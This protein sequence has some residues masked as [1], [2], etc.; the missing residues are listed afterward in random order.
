MNKKHLAGMLLLTLMV[1]A[2]GKDKGNNNNDVTQYPPV[3]TQNPNTSYTPAFQGQTRIYG[4]KT[5]AELDVKVLREGLQ[6]PWGL[7]ALPNGNWLVT[8]KNGTMLVLNADGSTKSTINGLPAVNSGGQGGLLG[9]ALDPQFAQNRMVYWTFSENVSGGTV[10]AVAKGMLA[11]NEGS[12]SNIDVI[13]RAMP[14]YQGQLHYGGRLVFDQTGNLLVSTGER[15]DL[16]TRPLAQDKSTGL[17]KILRI[18]REGQAAPGNP[19]ANDPDALPELYS[20]GHRNVQGLTYD[21]QT[22]ALWEVEFGPRGG[23]EVN[24]VEAGKNYGWPTITYGIEYGGGVIGDGLT[25]KEG[26]EQPVYYWDPSVSPSGTVFYNADYH[27]EWKGNLL[28]ACLSGQH[29]VRLRI[30]NGKVAGEER[31][32]SNENQR[33][34]DVAVGIDGKLYAITDQGRF[35]QVGKQ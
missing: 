1:S 15:S 4:I 24:K 19:F 5:Q 29:I 30:Q 10:T 23:D 8:Q 35:Y 17:G 11:E 20:Y 6:A 33:F 28:I 18:T 26:M 22:N 12:I 21:A 16:V 2:C 31:L 14:A 34:R 25:Q 7:V 27:T 3:E 32:L 13:Y 9:V